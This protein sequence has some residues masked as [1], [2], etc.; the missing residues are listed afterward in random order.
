MNEGNNFRFDLWIYNE[1]V[2]RGWDAI[3]LSVESGLSVTTINHYLRDDYLP[4]MYSLSMILKAFN[5]HMVF[6]SN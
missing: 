4:T 6:E 2:K 3:D 5:M 1:M